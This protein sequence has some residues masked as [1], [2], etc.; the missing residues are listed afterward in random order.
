M[1][2]AASD[3][4]D[5]FAVKPMDWNRLDDRK[6][7]SDAAICAWLLRAAPSSRTR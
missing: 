2:D 6:Y 7:M 4:A 5:A 1:P 3:F